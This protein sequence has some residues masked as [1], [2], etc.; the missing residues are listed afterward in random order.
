VAV[1]A[2]SAVAG[3]EVEARAG[4]I[5]FQRRGQILYFNMAHPGVDGHLLKYKI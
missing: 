4:V 5:E 1:L 2:V 3:R